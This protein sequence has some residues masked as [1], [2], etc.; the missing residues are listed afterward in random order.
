V[1]SVESGVN[2]KIT[3]NKLNASTFRSQHFTLNTIKREVKV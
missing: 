1:W 3:V 2:V